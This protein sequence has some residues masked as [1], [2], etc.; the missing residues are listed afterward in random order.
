VSQS[1][2]L[3]ETVNAWVDQTGNEIVTVSPPS[4]F[5]QWMDAER[6]TRLVVASVMVTYVPAIAP[7]KPLIQEPS[8]GGKHVP[9]WEPVVP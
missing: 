6:T 2:P 9:G 1:P 8:N 5:M 4:M 3:D 7:P